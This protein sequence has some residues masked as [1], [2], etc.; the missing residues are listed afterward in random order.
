MTGAR[1]TIR[2]PEGETEIHLPLPGLYNVYNALGALAA[3]RD[4]GRRPD[5]GGARRSRAM[6]AVFGRVETIA[7]RRPPGL[8]PADQEPRRRKRGAADAAPRGQ[9]RTAGIDLWIAL[10]DRIADGRD[11]SWVWDADFELLSGRRATGRLQRHARRRR[12]RCG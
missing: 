2:T 5:G 9:A 12:W 4:L 11:V 10:N 7:G 8:D 6:R 3:A 1:V